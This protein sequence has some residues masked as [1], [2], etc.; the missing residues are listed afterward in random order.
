LQ[1]IILLRYVSGCYRGNHLYYHESYLVVRCV[2]YYCFENSLVAKSSS[3]YPPWYKVATSWTYYC[4]VSFWQRKNKACERMTYHLQLRKWFGCQKFMS[5]LPPW[6]R[7]ATSAPYNCHI[8]FWQ[9]QTQVVIG[10][11]ILCNERC[12]LPHSFIQQQQFET[13]NNTIRYI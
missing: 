6:Y 4:H 13:L 7:V 3:L 10:W 8:H 11:F 5:L 2:L 1:S 9:R 12:I